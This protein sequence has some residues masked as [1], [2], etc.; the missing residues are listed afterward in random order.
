[1][2]AKP[3]YRL[4][5]WLVNVF[6]SGLFTFLPICATVFCIYWLVTL[7]DGLLEGKLKA[8]L[9]NAA[10]YQTGMGIAAIVIIVFLLGLLT[11]LWFVTSIMHYFG[12]LLERIPLVKTV[13][14]G[15][16]DVIEFL[17]QSP[18]SKEDGRMVV[19]LTLP[20]GW[21]QLGIVT[22]ADFHD[23]PGALRREIAAGD[24]RDG[25]SAVRT[26]ADYVAAYLPLSYPRGG[27]TYF[28]ER[29]AMRPVEGMTVEDAMRYSVMAW[30]SG[31]TAGK[32]AGDVPNATDRGSA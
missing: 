15:I 29:S 16:R 13:Y 19:M 27:F 26:D 25:A 24:P 7:S 3:K 1:M 14:G 20:G 31:K 23:L 10:A 12:R 6:I 11:K 17:F 5:H 32:T 28:I 30:M 2:N 18:G 8:W 21:K 4:L 22:R 9:P